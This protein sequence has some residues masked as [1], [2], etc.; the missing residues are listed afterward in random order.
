[1]EQNTNDKFDEKI[2]ELEETLPKMAV[3]VNCAELTLTS[4]L[5]VLGINDGIIN[6][7][8]TVSYTH[9]RAHET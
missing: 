7:L 6:N 8:M 3:G 9:L 2:K 5:D 1:M 4:I